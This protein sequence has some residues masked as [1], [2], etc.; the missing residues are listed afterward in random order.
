M[1][2]D[3]ENNSTTSENNEDTSEDSGLGVTIH[4]L[5]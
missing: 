1:D 5:E 2:E 3:I 4:S